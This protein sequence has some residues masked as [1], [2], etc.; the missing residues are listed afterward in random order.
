[1]EEK[2]Y[3]IEKTTDDEIILR[4]EKEFHAVNGWEKLLKRKIMT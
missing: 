1:M 3:R 2:M 4:R